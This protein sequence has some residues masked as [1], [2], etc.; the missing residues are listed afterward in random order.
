MVKINLEEIFKPCQGEKSPQLD[1]ICFENVQK[2]ELGTLPEDA[3]VC[4]SGCHPASNYILRV[5]DSPELGN[6]REVKLWYVGGEGRDAMG[7]PACF[8]GPGKGCLITK[9][10]NIFSIPNQKGILEIG[11]QYALPTF[12]WDSKENLYVINHFSEVR[13]ETYTKIQLTK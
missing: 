8:T 1:G 10:E 5:L 9:A 13:T 2:V 12:R 3:L 6:Q 4:F 7:N 11:K